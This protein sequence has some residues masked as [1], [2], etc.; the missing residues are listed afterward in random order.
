MVYSSTELYGEG[1]IYIRDFSG[2]LPS[3]KVVQRNSYKI[4][5]LD[6]Y[7]GT[8]INKIGILSQLTKDS[9]PER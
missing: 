7:I 9:L 2:D 8:I 1:S 3:S 6:N 4:V 5:V